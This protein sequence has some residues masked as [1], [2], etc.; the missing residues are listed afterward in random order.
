MTNSVF[1]SRSPTSHV[2]DND[3]YP[4]V[5][6]APMDDIIVQQLATWVDA[7]QR[8][9]QDLM[10]LFL[11]SPFSCD[12]LHRL[13]IVL[14]LF[15]RILRPLREATSTAEASIVELGYHYSAVHAHS[16]TTT[17]HSSSSHDHLGF[18]MAIS[19]AFLLTRND[20]ATSSPRTASSLNQEFV[21]IMTVLFCLICLGSFLP[22]AIWGV[23]SIMLFNTICWETTLSVMVITWLTGVLWCNIEI[24]IGHSLLHL[25]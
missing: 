20:G 18:L 16:T 22:L 11:H 7:T 10:V 8:S 19:F 13:S 14:L 21:I 4:Y 3:E 1:I 2:D 6:S 25:F 12:S 5:T 17:S 9:I 15:E 24:L 23:I